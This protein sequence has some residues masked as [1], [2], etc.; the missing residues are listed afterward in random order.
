MDDDDA[1]DD[2]VPF[3]SQDGAGA[4]GSYTASLRIPSVRVRSRILLS[5]ALR[6]ERASERGRQDRWM[7]QPRAEALSEN[8]EEWRKGGGSNKEQPTQYCGNEEI[9]MWLWIPNKS[10][11]V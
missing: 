7:D 8:E 6:R 5:L 1:A 9:I 2:V 11:Y 4:V 10:M 3:A